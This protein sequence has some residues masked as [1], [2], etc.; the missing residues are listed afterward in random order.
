MKRI[1]GI[2]SLIVCLNLAAKSQ[3]TDSIQSIIDRDTSSVIREV[4]SHPDYYRLKI[5]LSE[6][7]I[8]SKGFKHQT[9][10][11]F[12]DTAKEYF[13]PASLVKI[14]L[15]L[16]TLQFINEKKVFSNDLSD[17]L[18]DSSSNVNERSLNDDYLLMLSASDN[19]A[20]NRLY[21][22]VGCKYININL[23]KKGYLNTYLI[24]RFEQGG[25]QYHQTALPVQVVSAKTCE[26]LY[27]HSSDSIYSIIQHDIKDSLVGI[28]YYQN[29]SLIPKPK[30]F[31][32]HNYVD[33]KDIHDMMVSLKYPY[34]SN[35][36]SFNITDSQRGAI[37]RHLGTS[38]LHPNTVEYSDTSVFHSNFL[39]F[40]LFGQDKKVYYPNIEYFN[41]SA[42]AYGFLADCSYLYDPENRVEFFLTIYM[43]VNKDEILNDNKYDYDTIGV[44]F[45]KRLGEIIYSGIKKNK[46][47]AQ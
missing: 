16:T 28:A 40:T 19:N 1:W 33:I 46:T 17:F 6:I 29:D 26:T 25:V 43:Y 12:R 41:K 44:P 34:L 38:P 31:R 45:M 32:Y 21:N 47:I 36:R 35:H 24:H 42:M 10:W 2:I 20:F 37:I 9:S 3:F 30:S 11:S 23:M 5:L 22:M 27:S 13:Y 14:P 18:I 8:D 15:A 7:S 4:F 39:R